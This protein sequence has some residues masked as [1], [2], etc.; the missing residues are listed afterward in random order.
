V[1]K[2]PKKIRT[3]LIDF[4]KGK[5]EDSLIELEKIEGFEPQKNLIKSQINYFQEEYENAMN[6]DEKALPF[7]DQW[8]AGNIITEHFFAY[9]NSAILS[10][11]VE[12]A[13][14]F[15][16]GY[17]E[18]KIGQN[19][20]DHKINFYKHQISQHLQK[21]K[22]EKDLIINFHKP[23]EIKNKGEPI[24]KFY[25]QYERVHQNSDFKSKDA[26]G[27]IFHFLIDYGNTEEC[28]NYYEENWESV[29]MEESHLKVA[30][31]YRTQ[32]Q[33]DKSQEVIHR[34]ATKFWYPIEHLQIVPMKL[35]C[36][37]DLI[38]ILDKELKR[39]ILKTNKEK[40]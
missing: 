15:Y 40:K 32:N 39:E 18:N 27:Y 17:L 16:N 2:L 22:G 34:F 31:I 23:Y 4:R 29:I 26:I 37:E 28:L 36:Y 7:N 5:I 13:T 35:W 3:I 25:D 21:V 11:Q 6:Y 8:Y 1:T 12:K 9:S 33:I 19:L 20:P 30:Q 38:P 24:E 14:K 10:N